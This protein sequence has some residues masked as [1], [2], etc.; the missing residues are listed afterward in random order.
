MSAAPTKGSA[1]PPAFHYTDLFVTEK[2]S[3]TPFKKI[4]SDFVST[5]NVNREKVLKA[6][7]VRRGSG[8]RWLLGGPKGLPS[9]HGAA[10]RAG[11][12]AATDADSCCS[13]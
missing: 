7:H 4:S 6:R 3:D 11:S 8:L 5:I 1:H 9:S 2:P 13:I 10:G 12:A